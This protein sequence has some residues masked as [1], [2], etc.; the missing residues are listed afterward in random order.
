MSEFFQS[1]A[2]VEATEAEAPALAASVVGWLAAAG[3]IAADP[4]T[5]CSAPTSATRLARTTSLP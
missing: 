3:V 5:A 4:A 2:D 1:I